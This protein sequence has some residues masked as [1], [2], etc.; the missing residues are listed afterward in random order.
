MTALIN[1]L[2]A[3][4]VILP[5]REVLV[6]LVAASW[7]RVGGIDLDIRRADVVSQSIMAL[8]PEKRSPMQFNTCSRQI[9]KSH[10]RRILMED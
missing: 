10:L 6:K 1:S 5:V 3:R 9:N 7:T 4:E 8:A 2:A